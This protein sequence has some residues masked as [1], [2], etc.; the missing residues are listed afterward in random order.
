LIWAQGS[1][2]KDGII[3]GHYFELN[4]NCNCNKW[5]GNGQEEVIVMIGLGRVIHSIIH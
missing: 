4:C 3:L 5:R 2:T 1:I